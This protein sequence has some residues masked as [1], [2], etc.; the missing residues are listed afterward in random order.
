MDLSSPIISHLLYFLL[1]VSLVSP[2]YCSK[3][4]SHHLVNQT[5]QQ[6]EKFHKLKK[7]IAIHLQRIN[8]PAVK[9]IHSPDGDIIDCVLFHN[10]PAFDHPLL[11]GL[12]PSNLQESLKTLKRYRQKDNSSDIFQL[13][14]LSGESCPEGT[15]PIRRTLEED[16]LRAG[17]ISKFGKKL[18]DFRSETN[19]G[20]GVEYAIQG[21]RDREFY[22]AKAA[23]NVWVPFVEN[24]NELSSSKIW[25]SSGSSRPQDINSIEVGWQVSPSLYGD[26]RTRL[27]IYWTADGYNKTG[28]YNLLCSGFVQTN[29]QI[30]LGSGITPISTYNGQQYGIMLMVRRDPK[31]GNWWFYF[32]LQNRIGYWPAT[33]FNY[34]KFYANGINFGGAIINLASAGS[35]TFTQMGS[36]HFAEEDFGK[37]AHFR[38]IQVVDSDDNLIALP[39]PETYVSFPNCYNIKTGMRDDWENYFYYGGPGRNPKCV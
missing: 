14:S 35:H 37:A 4:S 19:G 11:K 15:I 10:Q 28:C 33:L 38:N 20:N 9:T 22:G 23:M 39:D 26:Q 31:D 2:I 1:L 21:V 12:K 24:K 8:K 27:T 6:E 3:T 7:K 29:H 32:G 25:I 18:N 5:F 17:S 16:I 34:L 36:G 30:A 13:W